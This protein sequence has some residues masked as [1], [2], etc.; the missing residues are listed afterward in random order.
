MSV[1]VP[2]CPAQSGGGRLSLPSPPSELPPGGP[3]VIQGEMFTQWESSLCLVCV[4]LK[5]LHTS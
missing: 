3:A 5:A 2:S 4:A 1:P